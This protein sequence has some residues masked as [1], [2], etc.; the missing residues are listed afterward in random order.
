M[1]PAARQVSVVA[2]HD[3]EPAVYVNGR[4]LEAGT[5]VSIRGKRGRFRFLRATHTTE[6]QPVLDFI[7][8]TVGHETWHSFYPDR[9]STVHRANTMRRIGIRSRK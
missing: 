2:P 8:G 9:I 3:G 7:G 1:S 6:G 5:E 4:P